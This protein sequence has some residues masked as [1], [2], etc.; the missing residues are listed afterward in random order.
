MPDTKVSPWLSCVTYPLG[1]YLLLPT[2]FG[3]LEIIGR[4]NIPRKGPVLLA[5]THR[6]RWDALIVPYTAGRWK[7]GRDLRYMV[8]ENEM[9]GLQGW[10]I[11]RMG[12]FPVDPQ[13][14]GLSSI[15]QSISVL[16]QGEM[17][18]IFPEGDIY[19]DQPVQPLKA[20]IGRIALQA[21]SQR[22]VK[23]SVKIVPM[24]IHYSQAYPN[25]GTQVKVQVGSALDVTDYEWGSM[26]KNAQRLI[27]DLE[28]AL[29]ELYEHNQLG[30]TQFS[31]QQ[32]WIKSNGKQQQSASAQ[33]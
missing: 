15:R 22:E 4:E 7:T 18:V 6:S 26:K 25:W 27:S 17:L 3:K 21:Q 28:Q 33:Q 14:P 23:E 8:S 9:R 31:S 29:K 13:H 20:G 5:P 1:C 19:R 10:F 16:S 24:S 11:S 2:Y 32:S 30:T 12:G